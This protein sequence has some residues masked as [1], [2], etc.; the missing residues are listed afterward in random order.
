MKKFLLISLLLLG[1][2]PAWGCLSDPVVRYYI[3]YMDQNGTDFRTRKY[4]GMADAWSQL[5][6]VKV[7]PHDLEW[8]PDNLDGVEQ[9]SYLMK[10]N[11]IVRTCF[12]GRHPQALSYLKTLLTVNKELRFSFNEWDYPDKAKIAAHN[13]KL[14]NHLQTARNRSTGSLAPQY[15]LMAMRCAFAL[16]DYPLCK[17]LWNAA[18]KDKSIFTE[19]MRNL[20]AGVLYRTGNKPEAFAIYSESG[21]MESAAWCAARVGDV[22]NIRNFYA[23]DPNN[24]VLNYLIRELC[25]NVQETVDA[26]ADHT[27]WDDVEDF[28]GFRR[29]DTSKAEEFISM[30]TEATQNPKVQDK[31]MWLNAAALVCYYYHDTARAANLIA[32]AQEAPSSASSKKCTEYVKMFIDADLISTPKQLSDWA[33]TILQ[34]LISKDDVH[35]T[36][37]G[38]RMIYTVLLPRLEKAGLNHETLFTLGALSKLRVPYYDDNGRI[39]YSYYY[40]GRPYANEYYQ[41][42]DSMSVD[43]IVS[44]HKYLTKGDCG[45]WTP[46]YKIMGNQDDYFNDLIGTRLLAQGRWSDAISY[47]EKVPLSFLQEQSIAPF[48]YHRNFDRLP[49]YTKRQYVN[50]EYDFKGRL[51]HNA[52]IDFC[53]YMLRLQEQP[54]TFDRDMRLAAA[55][56][57]ASHRGQCWYLTDYSYS[58]YAEKPNGLRKDFKAWAEDYVKRAG[59]LDASRILEANFA[60]AYMNIDYDMRE[61]DWETKRYTFN[62]ASVA[63]PYYLQLSRGYNKRIRNGNYKS[64]PYAIR[65]C[66]I[67]KQFRAQL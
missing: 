48:A 27:D 41:K 40:D 26:I 35:S 38:V 50:D 24:P 23:Q 44:W 5:L 42:L 49:W 53:K 2:F 62:P 19:M 65:T 12:D 37:M 8:L 20:Y 13:R 63:Y 18:P 15:R 60:L 55:L 31:A 58:W 51:T 14:R 29:I 56:F 11:S 54:E 34:G 32:K 3:Y 28:Y 64:I 4:Q 59:R 61:Y 52:K 1:M 47:L 10:N 33:P 45:A 67:L 43:S 6:G 21:D 17:A 16:K 46:I 66:D 7:S 25:N 57:N 30:A 36:H 9:D 22:E 39:E